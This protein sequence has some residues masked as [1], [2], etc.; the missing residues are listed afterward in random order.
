[1]GLPTPSPGLS[2]LPSGPAP[3]SISKI[4]YSPALRQFFNHVRTRFD[5]VLIDAPPILEVAD[6]RVMG[7]FADGAVLVLRAG[8]T[9]RS[10][11]LEACQHLHEDGTVLLGTVLNDWKPSRRTKN[12]YEYYAGRRDE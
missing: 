1:M 4:L 9:D 10:D 6:A 11:A 2:V 7:E 3:E 8:S 5:V 12:Y